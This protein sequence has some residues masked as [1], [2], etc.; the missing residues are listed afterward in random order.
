M[1]TK[2][3][4]RPTL[5]GGNTIAQAQKP[6]RSPV[7]LPII[8]G[9]SPTFEEFEAI[10]QRLQDQIDATWRLE[11]QNAQLVNEIVRLRTRV[12]T[13]TQIP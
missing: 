7:T 2:P 9:V 13:L 4:I 8:S 1:T 3:A 12:L 5:A 11:Q 6:P 10:Q